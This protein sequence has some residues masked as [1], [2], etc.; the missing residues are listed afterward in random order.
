MSYVC[1]LNM[2]SIKSNFRRKFKT[3]KFSGGGEIFFFQTGNKERF[4]KA[5][6]INRYIFLVFIIC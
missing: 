1:F 5:P 3:P 4:Y 2:N 6:L